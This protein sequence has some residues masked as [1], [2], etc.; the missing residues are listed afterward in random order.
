MARRYGLTAS[1]YRMHIEYPFL[2][3]ETRYTL[4]EHAIT[5]SVDGP[6]YPRTLCDTCQAIERLDFPDGIEYPQPPTQ[7]LR[8]RP[9]GMQG[10]VRR[11]S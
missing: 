9:V 6:E 10:D 7:E 11:P 3:G 8:P 1:G 2:V 4:C 5:E